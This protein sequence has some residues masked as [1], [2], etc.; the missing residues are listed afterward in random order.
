MNRI[1]TTPLDDP[2][3]WRGDALATR[4]DWTLDVG[5]ERI[6]ELDAALAGVAGVPAIE[7]TREQFPLPGWSG[8]VEAILADVEADVLVSC[9]A[10]GFLLGFVW[11]AC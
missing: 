10:H 1:V 8:L 5:D 9:P 7:I 11:C 3:A 4:S 2:A 6:A